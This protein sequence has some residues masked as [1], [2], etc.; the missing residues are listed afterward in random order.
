MQKHP[1]DELDLNA[2]IAKIHWHELQVHF[3]RG[4]VIYIAPTLDLVD[5]AGQMLQDNSAQIATLIEQGQIHAVTNAQAQQFY[6]HNPLLWAVVLPPWVLVQ[7]I[8]KRQ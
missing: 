4:R 6:A 2:E 5:V 1:L 7:E 8:A 3:A